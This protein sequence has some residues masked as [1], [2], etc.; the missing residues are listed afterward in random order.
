MSEFSIKSYNYGQ[1]SDAS[2]P[3]WQ[4]SETQS[5]WLERIGYYGDA[6]DQLGCGSD[7]N[8]VEIYTRRDDS[9]SLPKHLVVVGVGLAYTY[10]G[11]ADHLNLILLC[12]DL[13]PLAQLFLLQ[14]V[15]DALFQDEAGYFQYQ[16]LDALKDFIKA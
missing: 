4:S 1:W 5:K 11:V 2:L 13:A 12:R 8:G 3:D 6:T 14:S 7:D 15:F 10:I 9:D 16:R